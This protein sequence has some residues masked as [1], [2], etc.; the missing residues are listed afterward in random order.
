MPGGHR[1]Q[2]QGHGH[3]CRSPQGTGGGQ[4]ATTLIEVLGQGP[5]FGNRQHRIRTVLEQHLAAVKPDGE[6]IKKRVQELI[7][8]LTRFFGPGQG[9]GRS[10]THSTRVEA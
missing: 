5:P 1:L 9:V 7:E 8:Q 4:S 10:F 3:R 6:I 2:I